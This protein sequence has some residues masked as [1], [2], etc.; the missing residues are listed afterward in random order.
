M[1]VLEDINGHDNNGVTCGVP[2]SNH[3]YGVVEVAD[4]Q[5][6]GV[7]FWI[8]V[9]N[10]PGLTNVLVSSN[11]CLYANLVDTTNG[12]HEIFSAPGLVQSNVWQHVALTYNTNSGMAALYYNGTNVASTYLGV[13]TPKTTGDVLL[14][15]DMSRLTN[16]FYGG[17]M[18]EM[19][20]Y[21]RC[22]SASEIAAIY[23]VSALT[24]NRNTGKFDP[25]ITPALSLAEAQVSFGGLTNILL[26]ANTNWQMQSYSFIATTNSL[27]LQITG[28]EPG[29]L[30]DSFSVAE[31]PLGN[32]YYLPEQSLASLAGTSAH[33]TW[34]LQI[35]DNRTGAFITNPNQLISWQLQIV[36]QNNTLPGV[37]LDPEAPTTITVP[38]GQI[39]NLPVPVPSWANFATNILVSATAP[40]DMFFNQT[41]PPTGS[42]ADTTLLT[43]S[44]GGIGSPV[45]A[46]NPPVS[47]PPLLPGQTYYLGVRNTGAHAVTA[48]V[49]VNF[50]ITTLTNG[51]PVTGGLN[52]TNDVERYFVFNVSSNAY[53][54][55]FQLLQL[56]GNADL[57]VRKGTPLPTLLNTDY[58]SFN[59]ANADENIYVFTNSSPVPLS[60][61][62]W[63]LG[64]INRSSGPVT[65]A[66]LAKELD[67][68]TAPPVPAIIPLTNGVPFNFTAGPG[69]ALTNFF[70]FT[71]TNFPPAVRF[72][73]YNLSG[74][75]DLTVQT[76]AP[77]F[78]P[79]FFQTSQL[80]G[81]SPELIFMATNSALNGPT[82]GVF[83]NLN[84]QWFL[85]VP[86]RE[87]N[88]ITYTIVASLGT[89]DYFPAF[90]GAGGAGGG[91]GGGGGVGVGGGHGTNGAVYHV[92]NLD[93]SGPGSLRDAV[94]A[95]NRTVVFDVS[96]T[97]SLLSPLIITNSYLTLAG[98][99]APHGITVAGQMTTVT[100]V[101]D[102]IIRYIRFRP[103]VATTNGIVVWFNGFEGSGNAN[104]GT[105]SYFAGGWH[106][107]A[108]DIDMIAPPSY[109]P[110]STAYEGT[111]YID[112]D[113]FN[114]GTISTN[115][116]TV[117]G[118]NY[119][120]NFAYAQ[121]ADGKNNGHP[122]ALM[123]ALQN[124]TPLLSLSVTQPNDWVNLGWTKTSVVF[125]ATAPTTTL[126]FHSL[127]P[128][129]DI[130][131]V[132]LDAVSLTTNW[133]ANAH[134]GDS[135][136]FTNVMDVIADHVSTSWSTNDLVSVL[137]STN[138]TVQWSILADS[139]YNPTNE[140]GCGSVLRFGSGALS[141]NHNLYANNYSANPHLDDNLGLDFVNNVIYNWGIHSGYSGTNDVAADFT[142]QLN[143]ACNYLIAGPDTAIYSTN[144]AQ[145]NIAFWGGTTNTWIFQTNNDIDSDTNGILN[146][147]NTEWNMFTN[148][149]TPFERPFPLPPVP[150]DE[151]F[152]AYEKVLDFA[153]VSLFARDWA[154]QDIVTGVRTQT[155]RIISTPPL[156]GLVAWWPGEGNA[157]DI[158]GNNNN[159][160]P[161]NITYVTGEVRQAFHYNGSNSLITVPPS[162]SLA[163]SNLTIECWVFPTDS[164]RPC[165]VVEYGGGGQ[166]SSIALW[167]NTTGFGNS[168]P[169][170]LQ[171]LVRT[172][173][174]TGYLQVLDYNPDVIV[175][176]WNHLAFTVNAATLTGVL[177]CNGVQVGSD[178]TFPAGSPVT[179]INFGSAPV[180]LGY[181]DVNSLDI[182]PG[183]MFLGNL[184]EISIYN[185]ALTASEIAAIYDAGSA[186]KYGL[187]SPPPPL[188]SDQDGI[189]DYWET[190]FGTDPFVP[191]N[192]QLSTN[193]SYIGYTTL[194]EYLGWLAAPHAL[195]P[196]NTPVSVDLYRLAGDTGNLSF[197]VTNAVNGTVYLTNVLGSVT[198]TGPFSNSIAVFTPALNYSGYA[199]F[200]FF[201]T[202]NDTV[203][204][205]GPETVS[206]VVSAVP[207][208]Y[209]GIVTLTN[210][211]P[212]Y[213]PTGTNGVDYYRYDVSTN[214][215]GVDFQI[216]NAS[217]NVVLLAHYGLPLPSLGNYDYKTNAGV[218]T[219]AS[220]LVLPNSTPVPLTSGLW[221]L[222]VS[223]ASGSLVDYTIMVTELFAGT[224][225]PPVLSTNLP[226]QSLDEL[227]LLTVTNTATD[228]NT[229]LT[230][231]YTVTMSVDTNAMTLN[232]WP[233]T[234]VT[235]SPPPVIDA[236]GIITWTPS[237]AQGPGVYII[238]TIVTD[239]GLPPLSATNSFTVTV[240]E[241]N[242]P[243]VL[244]AQ[245]NRT[246]A[247]LTALIV[248]NTATDSD[249]PPNPLTYQ[250]LVSPAAANATIS[251]NGIITWTPTLAQAPGFY[252]FTTI[253][254]DTNQYAV[255]A[256]SLSATNVFTVTVTVLG[257]PFVFTQ[258]AQSVTGTGAQLNGMATP[259][260]LPTAA[261]FQ[262]GI[263]TNYGHLTPA[264]NV[265][266]SF[267]VVY[268][269]N[270]ISGLVANAPYHF[271][272]VASNA[273]GVVYGFDQ[274]LDEANVVVWGADYAGQ[275]NVPPGLSNVVAI[276]GAYD[277]SLA[278]KNNG[279]AVGWGDNTFGQ[280]NVPAG[281]NN[282]LAVAGGEYYSLA[283]KNSGTVAAWGANIL[284]QTNV[285]AGLNNVVTIAGGTYTSLALKNDGTVVAWGASFFGLT[286]VPAGLN[287]AVAIAG[288]GYHNL[289]IRNNGTVMVWGDNSDGQTNVPAGLTNVVAISG[290]NYHSLALKNDGTVVA[291]GDD[292]VGQTN[293]PAGLSNVVAIA[294]GGFHSLALKNDGTVVAWGDNTAGQTSVP[295]GL[296]N[297]VATASGYLHSL[298]L[299]PLPVVNPTNPVVLNLTNGVAQTNSILAGGITYYQVNVPP[300]ADFATNRLLFTLN[301]PLNVWFTTNSPPTIT[302]PGDVD[303]MPNATNGL[304]ILS[305]TSVPTNLV[306]GAT[307]YLGVQNPNSFTVNYGIEVDFHLLATNTIFITSITATNIGGKPG[308]L[309]QWQGPTNLLYEIQWTASLTPIAWNTILNPVINVSLTPTNGHYSF[310]DDGSLTGGLG[311][312]RFYR[313]LGT[314]NLG[315]LTPSLPTISTQTVAELTLLTV[316]NT[317]TNG[318]APLTYSVTMGVD[319]SAMTLNGWPLTYVTLNPPPV[320]SANG[321]ITWTPSEA[322][323]PG[324][325]IIRTIVTSSGVPPFSATNSFVVNVNEV[326]RAPYFLST[327]A[328]QTIGALSALTVTNAAGDPDIPANPLT[329]T[330]LNPPAGMTIDTNGVIAWTPTLAQALTT[331]L[332][333]TVVTD[334]NVYAPVNQHLS[335]TNTFTVRV[336]GITSAFAFTQPAQSVTGTGA[337]L[338]GM[339]T[340][341]GPPT[342]AWFE[343]GTS[344]AYGN[345]T[346]PVNV[347]GSYSVVHVS[348][349]ITNL[350]MNQP[351]HFRLVV[352]NAIGVV[353]GF[354]QLFDEANVV[355]W[356]ADYVGQTNVPPGLSNV[357]AVA[358]A[359]DHSLALKNDGTAVAWGDNTFGQTN[360]PSGLNNVVA[361]A[362]GEYYSLALKNSGTVAAWG[363][364]I[365]GQTNVPSGLNNVVT[366]AGGTYTS[367]ALKNDGT[368]VAWGYIA[369]LTNVPAGLSNAVA[370]AG[371]GSHNLAI[372]NDG[373]VVAWGDNSAGQ[374]NVPA[375][376][377][378]VVA[379]AGG[380]Y[381][382][383]A[384]KNDGT[385]VAWGDNSAGQTNLPAGL[386]NVVAVAAGG[387]H[388]LALR[389]DGK[390]LV[391][392]DNSTN[393]TSLPSGL[394]NGVAISCGYFHN[395][396]LAS[397]FNVNATNTPPFWV[398][399]N[400]PLVTLDELTTLSVTNIANDADLPPQ[401]LTYTVTML[402]DTNAMIANGWPLDYAITNPSPIINSNGVITW[403]PDEAQ[404]PGVYIINAVATD[405]GTPPLSAT[406]S[407]T[408]TVNEV[409]LP[410]VPP[411]QPDYTIS[412]LTPLVVNNAATDPDIPPNPLTYQLSGPPGALIDP[413]G[414]ITWTPTLAQGGTTNVFTTIVTDTNAFAPANRSLSATNSFT[415]VVTM[416]INLTDGQPQ[417]NTIAAGGIVYYAVPVPPNADFATNRLLFATAPVNVWFDTNTPPT[418]NRLLLPDVTYPTGTTGT[419]V[420]STNTT[421]PLVPGSTYYL[422]VQNTNA[423]AVTFAVTVDF[424][425]VPPLIVPPAIASIIATN[426]GGTNGFLLTW[427]APTN[428][429]F[430]VQWNA[431]LPPLNWQTF[432]NIIGYDLF[433]SPTNS[434]F[435]FFD[436]GS[437][438]GGFGPMRYYRLFRLG[439]GADLTN[440]A[441]QTN[442]LA[443]GG[444]VFYR[445]NVPANSDEATNRLLFATG[446]LNVWFTTNLPPTF[447]DPGDR[448]LI[449]N[450]TSGSAVLDTNSTPELVPGSTYYLGV[451]NTNGAAV[452]Y[453]VGVDFHL[454]LGTN[455]APPINSITATNGGFLL[456]WYAPTNFQ[457]Q[458]RWTASLTPI[459]WTTFS[460]LIVYTGPV[461]PANGRFWFL[462]DGTQF[463]PGPM[464]FYQLVL[465]GTATN[466][467]ASTNAVIIAGASVMTNG[468][469]QLQWTAATSDYFRVEWTTDL[470]PPVV[471]FTNAG[472][473]TSATTNF[474]FVDSNALTSMKFYRLIRY[475]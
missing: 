130:Y 321:I 341:N 242:V 411:S 190:T 280:T 455:A 449:T 443:S 243:P 81:R 328:N 48:V 424:H 38:P 150:T 429:H 323:G 124:G 68:Q 115:I 71:V 311:P 233:L 249:I 119:T 364:N 201:V 174:N 66:V 9:T 277:H 98:Q 173:N 366:I 8:S 257:A 398:A 31:A 416:S 386:S 18:D 414:I 434:R 301:G 332:I 159:G 67:L 238:T 148:F 396:A 404:G 22:L 447:A 337:Q 352:S 79:P 99:T 206:V 54:A 34:T 330:L 318:I 255:N 464:R 62:L 230:L 462:D 333:T 59:T 219:N 269:T 261:W 49:Q 135:L 95:T 393:Q 408:V 120:L 346:P 347:G 263:T 192:N 329:Y 320:I 432:T 442:T 57:V 37:E 473:I 6:N 436:D 413:N 139:L 63:Y 21:A 349:P 407:F 227:T 354:D 244:P 126:T 92:Y 327:P 338:N 297:V 409:N 193:A 309:L 5:T 212:Y 291:W 279:T 351:Y 110:Y 372:K 471:W 270:Q 112:L 300:N 272:L 127:D 376:L 245:T 325:Y 105:G 89:N 101:H 78:G 400:L 143:Y 355:A 1:W 394:S 229:N 223:N 23:N 3:I 45:L 28:L 108:G 276:A 122:T 175:N 53:E 430:M 52:T 157:N 56:S 401:A 437:Q 390:V 41:A 435:T 161:Q 35:W 100:N 96:G 475:P 334:F 448:L 102:L 83:T 207:V 84:T 97:I 133:V 93:D 302:S 142:N 70:L 384:L 419:A 451:Q 450:A 381:H 231:T 181:R 224:N 25:G 107:D 144:A 383:L 51:V 284:G 118:K 239:N 397:P 441:P 4:I 389:N 361:V 418:T 58:G 125:T 403:T 385:V 200:D 405:N 460:N 39:V 225:A 344:A 343:W 11:G 236:N 44:T 82:N 265:G 474:I 454:L 15:R 153:G 402:V 253:V 221:Y 378:N 446:P 94:S 306:P 217:G 235:T 73:L 353:H 256:K 16:N 147:A 134:P 362:G 46:A 176:Q 314:L 117:P 164:G 65:Y 296:S 375:G 33:G 406:N 172:E 184:D 391:W 365:L 202:N 26:G 75:G 247:V 252:T 50:D 145:T 426:I 458:V 128:A 64:V 459:A 187:L 167:I 182:M 422:G 80:P 313:V 209:G 163:V 470:L 289:A 36:L 388:S 264:V 61:G 250:L 123:E 86:N 273:V 129:G 137:D 237:E 303:L 146:G 262:W 415:V 199:S 214:A 155:G 14:G 185:R 370:I 85:G 248:T 194:E 457:F 290:G 204:W 170:G 275:A 379:I 438:T 307:Y 467:P 472:N 114:P 203:A 91:A 461:T 169:G 240:N 395:L 431:S 356:G 104:I 266:A 469:F 293:V 308:F 445:V 298:A 339:A 27:P 10:S 140:Q 342:T 371:G 111:N 232:G 294:A 246:I 439:S 211:V 417:T 452:A 387:Y 132:L 208:V 254:T 222:A 427:Y 152:L 191:S 285:P 258:P 278:L 216:L 363:A 74:N 42:P 463:P 178:V 76:N 218:G 69:A 310:F 171:A 141:F 183:F 13:F 179:P 335:A 2:P 165:P 168:Q 228:A 156:S 188:D 428:D 359:Y 220:I 271:R 410:P 360:V 251:T 195:T 420:L 423:G 88:P 12:G 113:G 186:G 121:N 377:A 326:N 162:T 32:L 226:N 180:N 55:T 392:G 154:D 295:V 213:D 138:V 72:E 215:V 77:P 283:L 304:S 189:P 268:T 166:L 197:F 440:G 205:F 177:Y 324:I 382:S 260:G 241:V 103:G 322:Q 136:Q 40:V 20:I 317:A 468:F 444:L 316:T 399:T 380:N 299:A 319:T 149:Y 465:V 30:L 234:Y 286:N 412:R 340:P 425:L 357:V 288:G 43:A 151:A 373:T 433:I 210:S 421:P 368:V 282:V 109:S 47:T 160:R 369:G 60:P 350:V 367:L 456:T 19:S 131:G 17:E 315:L 87:T 274:I 374:T 348:S 312:M 196:T 453:A 158:S 336:P 331:N 281:L 287:N 7:Q 198:N 345:Q 29:M 358:G 90:P 259:N 466:A 106:V 292:S 24:T 116:A 267:N 305:T